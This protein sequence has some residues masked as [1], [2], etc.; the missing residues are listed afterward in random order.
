MSLQPCFPTW[1]RA[2]TNFTYLDVFVVGDDDCG[3]MAGTLT[4]I[5][6][7]EPGGHPFGT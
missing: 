3:Q 7:C 2:R 5:F 6:I 1:Q 4:T